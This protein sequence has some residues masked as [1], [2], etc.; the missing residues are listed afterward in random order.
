MKWHFQYIYIYHLSKYIKY[1][2]TLSAK[3]IILKCVESQ[4]EQQIRE[5][6]EIVLGSQ[7]PQERTRQDMTYKHWT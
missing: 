7:G 1:Q 3:A 5:Y 6:S 4:Q 2:I